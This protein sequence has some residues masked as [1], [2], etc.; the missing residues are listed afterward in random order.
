M[1]KWTQ[2]QIPDEQVKVRWPVLQGWHVLLSPPSTAQSR[3]PQ[4]D[5]L[6]SSARGPTSRSCPAEV[7]SSR[8]LGSPIELTGC[9]VSD[10]VWRPRGGETGF[11]QEQPS[12]NWRRGFR[13]PAPECRLDIQ[14]PAKAL[15]PTPGGQPDVPRPQI[16]IPS[17]FV[18]VNSVPELQLFAN[19]KIRPVAHWGNGR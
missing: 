8:R 10:L 7:T 1:S 9:P 19:H 14:N 12:R 13:T 6:T 18:L 15:E 4:S 5:S 11:C 3:R 16:G 2:L 17:H